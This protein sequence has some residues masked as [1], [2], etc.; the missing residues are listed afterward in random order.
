MSESKRGENNPNYSNY[1]SEEQ[2]EN[3]SRT[4]S[5][6]NNG[7]Y[8]RRGEKAPS[9]RGGVRKRCIERYPVVRKPDHP[10][11]QKNGCVVHHRLIC[12]EYYKCMILPW[13]DVHHINRNKHDNR[14]EN[15]QL[16]SHNM[17]AVVT[18]RQCR[19]VV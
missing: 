2:K 5:G 13:V 1:W 12:E 11:A 9:Y 4:N 17:H 7:M 19:R 15:L 18:R 16:L 6:E 8:G 14:I 3:M 10:F